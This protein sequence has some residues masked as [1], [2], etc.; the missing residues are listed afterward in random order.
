MLR[1]QRA[2]QRAS[3][4]AIKASEILALVEFTLRGGARQSA[5][6]CRAKNGRA[7]PN[8]FYAVVSI[9]LVLIRAIRVISLGDGFAALGSSLVRF[10]LGLLLAQ[11]FGQA[12]QEVL[13][14]NVKGHH[15]I[16]A[17]E[18][19]FFQFI[20]VAAQQAQHRF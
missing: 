3:F 11:C 6:V 4:L 12:V 7:L 2:R 18:Q 16:N 20:L 13:R 9:E 17:A 10:W 19:G 8:N 1:R 15:H 5:A 14:R